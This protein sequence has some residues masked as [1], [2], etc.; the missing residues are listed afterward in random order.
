MPHIND[1]EDWANELY[2]QLDR[3]QE[4]AL[5]IYLLLPNGE[6]KQLQMV[7]VEASWNEENK[8]TIKIEVE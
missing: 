1:Q 3:E 5:E 4:G 8:P 6:S 2:Q 7:N